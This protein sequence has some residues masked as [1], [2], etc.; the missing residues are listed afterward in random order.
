MDILKPRNRG[1]KW[2]LRVGRKSRSKWWALFL[3]GIGFAIGRICV[4]DFFATKVILAPLF[5]AFE[6]RP[7]LLK[8]LLID[9]VITEILVF[10][11]AIFLCCAL[12]YFE[13]RH[14]YQIIQ[15]QREYITDQL[16]DEQSEQKQ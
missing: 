13:R 11:C 12:I 6:F 5:E 2:V 16:N 15:R 1:E 7:E 10:G 8:W 3:L 14:F 4:W 9:R